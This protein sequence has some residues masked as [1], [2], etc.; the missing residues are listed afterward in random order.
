MHLFYSLI[1]HSKIN[2]LIRNVNYLLSPL[3]PSKIKIPPSGII[4]IRVK[5]TSLFYLKTNQ[6]SYIT[7][8][9][10]WNKPDNF[11]YTIIFSELISSI[12]IFL[13]IGA[14]IGYYSIL[15]AKINPNMTTYAFEPSVGARAYLSDN[16]RIN[17]LQ[18]II[19]IEP[20]ALSNISSNIDFYEVK[21]LKF[22]NIYNL[23]G[24]HNIG[25]KE[26]R[27]YNKTKVNSMTLDEYV[28]LKTIKSID[29][30]KL[31]TEGAESLILEGAYNSI[32]RFRPIIICETLFNKL[33]EKLEAIMLSHNYLFFNH[34]KNGLKHVKTITRL[35]DNNIRNCFFVPSEKV[36]IIEKWTI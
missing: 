3:L 27:T 6:T 36:S 35:K 17:A 24:E 7:K 33:E 21:N 10:F 15:G 34:T 29:L 31:D 32:K 4:K 9:L 30:I 25:T 11:E 26:N 23:S 22:P 20:F 5:K 16:I 18:N 14:N 28:T 13:D 19:N 12:N 1:Y 2:K 8:E